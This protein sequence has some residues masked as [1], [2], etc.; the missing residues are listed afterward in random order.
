MIICSVLFL[1]AGCAGKHEEVDNQPFFAWMDAY[2]AV[3]ANVEQSVAVTMFFEH[4]PFS[5]DEIAGISFAGLKDQVVVDHFRVDRPKRLKG[6][7]YSSYGITL[8]YLAKATGRYQ[9][10]GIVI[11]LESNEAI[12]YPIGTWVFDVG[13][14]GAGKVNTWEAPAATANATQFPYRFS[15]EHS[16]GMVTRIYYSPDRYIENERGIP[17][18]GTIDLTEHYSSPIVY[19]RSKIVLSEDGKEYMDYGKGCYCGAVN[20]T[21]EA[22]EASRIHNQI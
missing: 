5:P 12:P 1:F 11:T 10:S 17:P 20:V 16:Q 13:E 21:E 22:I 15:L 6:Q 4:A 18:E 19:I 2:L 7:K 8:N 14:P 9:T 3:E